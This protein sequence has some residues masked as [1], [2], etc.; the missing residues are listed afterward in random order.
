MIL[1]IFYK[2]SFFGFI[3]GRSASRTIV[4]G[5]LGERNNCRMAQTIHAASKIYHF[6]ELFLFLIKLFIMK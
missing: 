4:S 6:Y 5:A 3:R 2:I 1:E